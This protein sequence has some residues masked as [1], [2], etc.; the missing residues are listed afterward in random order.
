MKGI[1]KTRRYAWILLTV[2]L[3]AGLFLDGGGETA[4]PSE[5]GL[6]PC[7]LGQG[8]RPVSDA[9]QTYLVTVPSVVEASLSSRISIAELNCAFEGGIR[10]L[11]K[12]FSIK[13]PVPSD[14]VRRLTFLRVLR[15]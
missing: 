10:I 6:S 8:Q 5:D 11:C 3:L 9:H 14:C 1:G 2:M 4:P 7:V 12:V 15:I 13:L